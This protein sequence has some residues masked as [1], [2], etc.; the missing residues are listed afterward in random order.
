MIKELIKLANHLDSK[1]FVKEADYLDRIIKMAE[2]PQKGDF[3]YSTHF[4]GIRR[5][6]EGRGCRYVDDKDRCVGKVSTWDE[7]NQSVEYWEL[8]DEKHPEGAVGT[9]AAA[10]EN[11]ST[12]FDPDDPNW[13]GPHQS[14]GLDA[15]KRRYET[16]QGLMKDIERKHPKLYVWWEGGPC[17]GAM[18]DYSWEDWGWHNAYP[19]G[20][21]T[22]E[23]ANEI[24]SELRKILDKGINADTILQ[25]ETKKEK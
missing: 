15:A 14:M 20:S 13:Q 11:F 6:P 5:A 7:N 3:F 25:M 21:C 12:A 18:S 23:A 1:G 9:A 2:E 4:K 22:E 19:N 24:I 10:G 17:H 8:I 16:I